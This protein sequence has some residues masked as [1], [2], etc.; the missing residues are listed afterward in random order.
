MRR[1]VCLLWIWLNFLALTVLL[2]TP[3]HGPN[4]NTVSSSTSIVAS[5]SFAA[6]MCLPR[7]CLETALLYLPIW[8]S[9]HSNGS[10]RYN[11][12]PTSWLLG[13]STPQKEPRDGRC[14]AF[15]L[16]QPANQAPN[17]AN[18]LENLPGAELLKQFRSFYRIRQFVTVFTK[19]TIADSWQ[20]G[21]PPV[22]GF[23]DLRTPL[24]AII[25]PWAS[26]PF[27][28]FVF[29]IRFFHYFTTR[30]HRAG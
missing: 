4:R 9:L 22:W 7:R 23:G 12:L 28:R 24:Q 6:G 3:S 25:S 13:R 11:I 16:A 29:L 10:T 1:W 2:T 20:G 21:C 19:L 15:G 18:L 30:I 27:S 14:W 8:R 17:G 5:G 26:I